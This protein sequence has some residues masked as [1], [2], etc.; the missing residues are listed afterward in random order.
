MEHSININILQNITLK[1][2]IFI[3]ENIICAIHIHRQAIKL[4]K[5]LVSTLEKFI[6]CFTLCVVVCFTLNLF[7]LFQI[8]SSENNF[9]KFFMPLMYMFISLLYMFLTNYIGQNI[10]D[11]NNHVYIT[12]Y[13]I[14]WYKT[15]LNIQKI[16]LFLLQR[17][18]K[19]FTLSVGGIFD[20]SME[21]FATLM[22][23]SISY[24]TVIYSTK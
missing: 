5:Q 9:T 7:Q 21:C 4:C 22:K 17:E 14:K 16:I 19:E 15:P 20:A 11:Y 6:F 18:T 10:I 8:A 2:K 13:N 3:A 1:N 24:F 23:A 12:A